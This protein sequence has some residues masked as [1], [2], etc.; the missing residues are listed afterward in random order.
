MHA[1]GHNAIGEV[2]A[3]PHDLLRHSRGIATHAAQ[4]KLQP[5]LG[6][7]DAVDVV[8]L[9][10]ERRVQDEEL[11]LV[12]MRE[13]QR[14]ADPCEELRAEHVRVDARKLD[15]LPR[16]G[17]CAEQEEGGQLGLGAADGRRCPRSFAD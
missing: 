16:N 14:A 2:R 15:E 13:L 8:V 6:P 1:A 10:A 5:V 17:V 11:E 7:E 3:H 9:R 12:G 4:V